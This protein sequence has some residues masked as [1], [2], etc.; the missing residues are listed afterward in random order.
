MAR[1]A[2]SGAVEVLRAR[3]R[4][5][6]TDVLHG[7]HGRAAQRVIQLLAQKV[8]EVGDLLVGQARRRLPTLQR[9][10]FLQKRSNFGAITVAK[11]QHGTEEVRT[12]VRPPRLR[13]VTR[14]AFGNP[15]VLA[16]V[17]ERKV[18]E[19]FVGW[20]GGSASTAAAT[21][22]WWIVLSA[23]LTRASSRG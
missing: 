11:K 3:L 6:R 18:N 20:A 19:R 13:A 9:M 8:R 15:D 5:T 7:E 4:I 10:P 23:P 22:W 21:R 2:L 12:G 17:G 1:R 14:H 16:F